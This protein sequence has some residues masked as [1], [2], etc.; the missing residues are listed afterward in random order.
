MPKISVVIPL[1]N[2]ARHIQ[3]AVSSVLAQTYPDFELIVVDDGSTDGSGDVVRRVTD[4]R[5]RLI[6]QANAGV[7]AARNRGVTEAKTDLVA[8]LDADDEWLPCFLDTAMKL[9]ARYPEAG[10]YATAYRFCE[11]EKIWRPAFAHCVTD[12]HGGLLE[13]YFRAALG[14]PPVWTSAVMIPKHVFTEVGLF[15]VGVRRGQDLHTWVRIALR[16]RVAWSP[17]EGAIYHLSSDN[18]ACRVIPA[19]LDPDAIFTIPIEEFLRS[20]IQPVT[21]RRHVEEYCT[22]QRL[23]YA[24]LCCLNGKRSWALSHIARTRASSAF[25]KQRMFLQCI[26]WLPAW[27]IKVIM[28][29]K[30][31]MHIKQNLLHLRAQ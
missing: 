9:Q 10:M 18:R 28:H 12:P 22:A 16:Y 29:I 21:S 5:I 6:T 19:N 17:I 11:G 4:P 23:K 1:Y 2:K 26:V 31:A 25:G 20:D 27:L 13:D 30:T 15:P 24:I 3:R 7:S 14:P 8:F